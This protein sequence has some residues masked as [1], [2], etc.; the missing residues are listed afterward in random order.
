[1]MQGISLQNEAY[2][3][4]LQK[5]NQ[6]LMPNSTL[7]QA[8]DQTSFADVLQQTIGTL[9]QNMAVVNQDTQ[10]VITGKEKDL[11]SVMTRMT[12]AQ[13]TLQTAVQVRNKCLE[14][15]NDLKNMQF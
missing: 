10:N 8:K 3:Q 7:T 15:Y 6:S 14:A 4:Q 5:I 13:L 1:M 11:G 12:E 9:N 2:Q